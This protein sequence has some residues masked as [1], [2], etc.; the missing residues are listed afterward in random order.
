MHFYAASRTYGAVLLTLMYNWCV[1]VRGSFRVRRF[2]VC[3]LVCLIDERGGG[4]DRHGDLS[5]LRGRSEKKE[6]DEPDIKLNGEKKR[7]KLPL[8]Q[9]LRAIRTPPPPR[10]ADEVWTKGASRQGTRALQKRAFRNPAATPTG[11]L[12]QQQQYPQNEQRT[13][14]GNGSRRETGDYFIILHRG[15]G[16]ASHWSKT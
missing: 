14:G 5:E 7:C 11:L 9:K 10:R 2:F 6:R 1:L 13:D 12:S 8:E 15:Q 3:R 4:A 16:A